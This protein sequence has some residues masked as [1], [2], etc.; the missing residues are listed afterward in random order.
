[1]YR[2]SGIPQG[3]PSASLSRSW[4]TPPHALPDPITPCQRL[5]T[6]AYTDRRWPVPPPRGSAPD[7]E[8]A[9][10]SR[11]HPP[12]RQQ[13]AWRTGGPWQ[14]RRP[15]FDIAAVGRRP[16]IVACKLEAMRSSAASRTPFPRN[17]PGFFPSKPIGRCSKGGRERVYADNADAWPGWN[18]AGSFP[19]H[20]ASAPRAASL[21][22]TVRELSRSSTGGLPTLRQSARC[23]TARRTGD[24]ITKRLA[25]CGS[26]HQHACR[27]DRQPCHGKRERAGSRSIWRHG[28]RV[29]T[30]SGRHRMRG[31]GLSRYPRSMS[32]P[33]CPVPSGHGTQRRHRM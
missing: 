31:G 19:V 24:V 7:D 12:A 8:R 14:N 17:I 11:C 9:G 25:E 26:G 29:R 10:T 4:A 6:R 30:H 18:V 3:P 33:V 28:D 23:T 21:K 13:I 16:P 5:R 15:T 22:N 1:M 32:A 20:V 27:H 2:P